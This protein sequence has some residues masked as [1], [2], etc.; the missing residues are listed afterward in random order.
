MGMNNF[1]LVGAGGAIGSMLRYA[2]SLMIG[3]RLFPF[4]TLTVNIVGS[5]IIGVLLGL[6]IKE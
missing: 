2:T 5:L 6:S 3:A 4:A 1:L